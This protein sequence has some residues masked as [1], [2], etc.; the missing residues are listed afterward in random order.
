MRLIGSRFG[1]PLIG[2]G[3]ALG[4]I[5]AAVGGHSV[6]LSQQEAIEAVVTVEVKNDAFVFSPSDMRFETGKLYKLVLKN[7][8]RSKHY[9]TA[10]QF[11]ASVWTRKVE[12]ADAEIKGAIREI[13]LKPSGEAEWYL[14][15]VQ[16]GT[17]NVMCSIDDHAEKGMVGTITV[18]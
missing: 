4:I 15:P 7:P 10:L 11:A 6:D 1:H 5:A 12:T 18:D 13:E 2:G 16:A 9:F 8:S 3:V 14:V 17:F